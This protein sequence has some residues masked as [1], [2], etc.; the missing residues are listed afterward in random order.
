VRTLLA[1]PSIHWAHLW[2]SNSFS[3]TF[4]LGLYSSERLRA[5]SAFA[6]FGDPWGTRWYTEQAS[7]ACYSLRLPPPRRLGC[8]LRRA[9]HEDCGGVMVVIVRGVVLAS[10]ERWKAT[11]V[12]S[13]FGRFIDQIEIKR[14]SGVL[15]E[16]RLGAL[17]PPQ[18][19]LGVIGKS[20]IPQ[21]KI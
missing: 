6:S 21:D 17:N 8:C 5:P 2:S 3:H 19:G 12:E 15:I 4:C 20:L 18:R 7:S 9:L 14:S 11:L 1:I 16:E 13:S 10:S